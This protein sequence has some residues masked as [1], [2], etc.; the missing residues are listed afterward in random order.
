MSSD[1]LSGKQIY[2]LLV[3]AIIVIAIAAIIKYV[4]AFLSQI[5]FVLAV[6][7]IGYVSYLLFESPKGPR[8]KARTKSAIQPKREKGETKASAIS[9]KGSDM[10]AEEH[11]PRVV[12]PE[13][14]LEN[15][16][17]ETIEGIG[18]VYGK[19]LRSAGVETVHNL[20]EADPKRISEICEVSEL[21][22]KR[23]IGMARFSWLNSVSEE[24]AEAI[25][26]AARITTVKSLAKAN[27]GE[28]LLT[29]E[30]AIK[31]GEVRVPTGY[32]FSLDRVESWIEEA[33]ELSG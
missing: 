20:I 1:E 33:K 30:A 3:I 11:V 13:S 6:V 14:K 10:H 25:V 8:K 16:P 32:K 17:I 19:E 26:L 7:V 12:I 31:S 28:L 4:D 24:D 29:I 9:K 15:L 22:A 2:G 21:M 18:R 5:V 23:W 27:A